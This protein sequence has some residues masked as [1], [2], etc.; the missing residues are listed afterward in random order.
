MYFIDPTPIGGT[1]TTLGI[2]SSSTWFKLTSELL[3]RS[4]N[5]YEEVSSLKEC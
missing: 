5:D 3:E 2:S 1:M 4:L